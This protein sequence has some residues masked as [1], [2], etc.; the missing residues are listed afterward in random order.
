MTCFGCKY[1]EWQR[2]KTG[3]LHPNKQGRCTWKVSIPVALYSN[4]PGRFSDKAGEN[5]V[6]EGH[7]IE[8]DREHRRVC[9]VREEA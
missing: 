2:T 4:V 6:L 5:L 1:A 8:R 9:M 7:W 3:A